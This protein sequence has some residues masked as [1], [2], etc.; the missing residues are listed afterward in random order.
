[1]IV[2]VTEVP[3][4]QDDDSVEVVQ[5]DTFIEAAGKHAVG[6][7]VLTAAGAAGGALYGAVKGNTKAA[8]AIGA[9][10]GLL[11][12]L[13]FGKDIYDRAVTPLIK[14]SHVDR[15]KRERDSPDQRGR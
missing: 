14:E 12:S 8:V 10:I 9:G 7:G 3:L 6:A 4:Q 15:L 11:G 5:P 1:M 2:V 13:G